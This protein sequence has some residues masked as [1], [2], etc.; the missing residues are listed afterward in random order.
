MEA[1]CAQL[2]T[3]EVVDS[4]PENV[5]IA[6]HVLTKDEADQV[7]EGLRDTFVSDGHAHNVSNCG[8]QNH[9]FTPK[10]ISANPITKDTYVEF[11]KKVGETCD[12]L[13][14]ASDLL[15]C[16]KYS[17]KSNKP[18][19]PKVY[20]NKH[21]THLDHVLNLTKARNQNVEQCNGRGDV[22]GVPCYFEKLAR[23][24]AAQHKD[25]KVEII[26]IKGDDL[27]TEGFRLMHGVG[28]AS[29]NPPVF[30]NLSYKGNPD[31]DH[32]VSYVGK[33]VCF[34]TGGLNIKAGIRYVLCSFWNERYVH[35]QMRSRQCIHCFPICR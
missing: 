25:D 16:H 22:E 29:R 23:D 27:V 32:W 7:P 31:S 20:V 9:Y 30:I 3:Y 6:Y 8:K 13:G 11:S 26:T 1:Q 2:P 34:D 33:G 5:K 28:R 18:A 10:K 24:F 15:A 12:Y 4:R 21:T 14:A 19:P 35:G 17:R